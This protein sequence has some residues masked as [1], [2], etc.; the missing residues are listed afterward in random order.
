MKCIYCLSFP[1][2]FFR[3]SHKAA[4]KVLA[5][6]AVSPEAQIFFQAHMILGRSRLLAP[7]ELI[8]V[9]PKANGKVLLLL[10]EPHLK[11]SPDYVRPIQNNLPL[12]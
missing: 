3:G 10:L 5:R 2:V 6:S 4:I 7:V 1:W 8:V 12:Y 11:G 9:S